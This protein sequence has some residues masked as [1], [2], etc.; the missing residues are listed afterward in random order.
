M[1]FQ[2]RLAGESKL[3]VLV[4][5]QFGGL[6]IDKALHGFVPLRFIS[7]ALVG[8]VGVGVHL[9]V[10]AIAG[11]AGLAFSAAQVVATLVAMLAN[12]QL[13]NT[14]TYR[15]ERLR[16]RRF[17]SGLVLFIA[18]CSLGAVANVGIANMIY[19]SNGGWTLPA[20]LG[21]GVGVIWNYAMS[22]TLVWGRRR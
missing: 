18:L 17:W 10:L 5:L 20:V 21:A 19:A 3:D 16:G 2:P 4:V 8:L 7:F 22:S 12:F 6:L 14:V 15:S 1:R 13:N 11:A 9:S